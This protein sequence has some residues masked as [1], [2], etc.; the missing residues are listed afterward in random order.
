MIPTIFIIGKFNV[1]KSNFYNNVNYCN[2]NIFY[3][4]K[5]LTLNIKREF[6][7]FNNFNYLIFDTAGFNFFVNFNLNFNTYIYESDIILF[8]IDNFLGIFYEDK[9]ISNILKNLKKYIFLVINKIDCLMININIFYFYKLGFCNPYL[10][11]SINYFNIFYILRSI[12][13]IYCF[14]K[15]CNYLLLKKNFFNIFFL[16]NN[17]YQLSYFN[18]YIFNKNFFFVN[19][20]DCLNSRLKFINY[21][22]SIHSYFYNFKRNKNN[23]KNIFFL[24]FLK[25]I[26]L[27]DILF[28]IINPF[29]NFKDKI[30]LNFILIKNVKYLVFI[31][32]SAD[33]IDLK[34]RIYF[35][36]FFKNKYKLKFFY[37]YFFSIFKKYNFFYLFYYFLKFLKFIYFRFNLSKFNFNFK[38]FLKL[39]NFKKI[40]YFY[41]KQIGK[42]PISIIINI[43]K[44]FF[45]KINNFVKILKNYFMFFFKIKSLYINLD[46]Y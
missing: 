19:F 34:S 2:T 30:L 12:L 38:N 41:L 3:N 37:I 43:K 16:S 25:K 10:I 1:G 7:I 23:L 4:F 21:N 13:N 44:P 11:N 32:N 15:K 36:Y 26:F 29:L 14:F 17:K 24:N 18:N 46:I 42:N 45:K 35:L 40:K 20:S 5:A 27:C 22:F 28:I 33:I 9:F 6:N 8:F 31:I 39:N